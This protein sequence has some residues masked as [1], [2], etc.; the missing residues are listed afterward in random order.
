MS[1]ERKSPLGDRG[2]WIDILSVSALISVSI[3]AGCVNYL[4]GDGSITFANVFW[5]FAHIAAWAVWGW[6]VL[7]KR[8]AGH[9]SRI[10]YSVWFLLPRRA[11]QHLGQPHLRR[12]AA[13]YVVH[14]RERGVPFH[15]AGKYHR[16]SSYRR[17]PS[18]VGLRLLRQLGLCRERY[19]DG[20]AFRAHAFCT[21]HRRCA[22][23]AAADAAQKVI[24]RRPGEY[25]IY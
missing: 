10:L 7:S 18:H 22:A 16:N 24:D 12:R 8:E 25:H 13:R 15:R 3:I 11:W 17:L 1:K 5:S 9:P 6:L 2:Y 4:M 20:R 14:T 23:R 19:S 21:A